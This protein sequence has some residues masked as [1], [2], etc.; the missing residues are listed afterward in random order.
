[1]KPTKAIESQREYFTVLE[2]Y[3]QRATGESVAKFANSTREFDERGRRDAQ[4]LGPKHFHATQWFLPRAAEYYNKIGMEM[5]RAAKELGGVKF[6]LGGSTQFREPHF[7]S[8]KKVALYADTVLIPDPVLPWV[9]TRRE[10]EKFQ[11][12]LLLRQVFSLLRLKP[13]VDADFPYPPIFVFQSWEKSLQDRDAQT[14]ESILELTAGV[15][16]AHVGASF[17]NFHDLQAF[18][19]DHSSEFLEAVERH[20]LFVAPGAPIGAPI[21]SQLS[22][23]MDHQREWRTGAY[24]QEL[25]RMSSAQR[26]MVGLLER[27]SHQFHLFENSEELASNPLLAVEQQW[28][29]YELSA[30]AVEKRLAEKGVLS[31]ESVRVIRSMDQ[32]NLQW[33]GNVPVGALVT[34]RQANENEAFRRQLDGFVAELHGAAASDLDRVTAQV[35]HAIA[36][37]LAQ[38][39]KDVAGIQERYRKSHM[40]T[41][42]GSWLSAPAAFLPLLG[43][44]VGSVVPLAV[45]GNYLWDKYCERRDLNHASRSLMGVLARVGEDV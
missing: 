12:V 8:V 44:Y 18:A 9:E 6:V 32:P 28:H 11:H 17:E 27:M 15:V 39:Q 36:S 7:A 5:F 23:F 38:H 25:E 26:V 24:L 30:R 19:T 35:G 13:L 1:M 29:Y 22:A 40:K 37:L 42:I 31:P 34:L 16:G 21:A 43:P 33:L 45:L 20:R 2:E 10:E 3:F 14:M 41:F 4:T